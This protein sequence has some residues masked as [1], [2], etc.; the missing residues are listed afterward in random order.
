VDGDFDSWMQAYGCV[1]PHGDDLIMIYNGNGFGGSGFGW[2]RL[3]GGAEEC[4]R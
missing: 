1:M 2:T 3:P 4:A